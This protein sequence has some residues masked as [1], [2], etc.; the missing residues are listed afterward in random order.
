MNASQCVTFFFKKRNVDK[1]AKMLWSLFLS[2][3][4]RSCCRFSTCHTCHWVSMFWNQEGCT[5]LER[6]LFV[7]FLRFL[8]TTRNNNTKKILTTGEEKVWNFQVQ[9]LWQLGHSNCCNKMKLINCVERAFSNLM[10]LAVHT[11]R[12]RLRFFYH[13]KWVAWDLM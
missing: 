6:F 13:S 4:H 9:E 1:F 7:I 12:L 3:Y 10:F 5:C 2:V 11:V 8:P